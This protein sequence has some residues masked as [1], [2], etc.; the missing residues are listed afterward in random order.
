MGLNSK[1]ASNSLTPKNNDKYGTKE[2]A[3]CI[4]IQYTDKSKRI[5]K[6][7]RGANQYPNKKGNLG[8]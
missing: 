5:R 7:K 6:S 2:N 3:K 1:Q 4:V 8:N